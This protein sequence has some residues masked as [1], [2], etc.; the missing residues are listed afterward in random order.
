[1]VPANSN[2][3]SPTP[4]YSG[5]HLSPRPSLTGLSPSMARLPMRFRSDSVSIPWSYYPSSAVT[6]KVWALALSLATTGAIISLF[7][8]PPGT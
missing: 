1:M 2:G 3:A 7:S 5:Y 6:E 8:L 4:P